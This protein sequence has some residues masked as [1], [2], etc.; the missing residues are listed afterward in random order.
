MEDN[1]KKDEEYMRCAPEPWDGRRS[2]VWCMVPEMKKGAIPNMHPRHCIPKPWLH[3]AYWKMSAAHSCSNSLPGKD[4]TVSNYTQKKMM[5]R[6]SAS[7]FLYF[8]LDALFQC[9]N[10]RF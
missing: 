8:S 9:I 6:F 1:L 5:H 4:K 2:A 3:R 10:I 7:S